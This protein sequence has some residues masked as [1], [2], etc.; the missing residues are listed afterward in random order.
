M[1]INL[2]PEFSMKILESRIQ[3]LFIQGKRWIQQSSSDF[4]YVHFQITIKS[5]LNNSFVLFKKIK[6]MLANLNWLRTDKFFISDDNSLCKIKSS[7][8]SICNEGKFMFNVGTERNSKIISTPFNKKNIIRSSLFLLN[9]RT[10]FI[11]VEKRWCQRVKIHRSFLGKK[12]GSLHFGSNPSL[13][14]FI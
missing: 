2:Q 7:F 3:T 8:H 6:F 9:L 12:N 11:G 13:L 5:F 4:L 1:R 10:V 14:S